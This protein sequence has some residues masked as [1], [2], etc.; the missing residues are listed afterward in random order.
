MSYPLIILG[1]GASYDYSQM[2]ELGE[3]SPLTNDLVSRKHIQQDLLQTYSG[4][5]VIMSTIIQQVTSGVRSFEEALTKLRD[6]SAG[7]LITQSH[8]VGLEFYLQKFFHRIS[9]N[10]DISHNAR[11]MHGINNY[12]SLF[13]KI[14][15]HS[16]GKACLVTFNYDSLLERN[17]PVNNIKR[18]NDYVNGD[19]KI[20][21]LHGSHDWTYIQRKDSFFFG[22]EFQDGY[23]LCCKEPSFLQKIKETNPPI[24]L[25]EIES[26]SE[27]RDFFK[28]PALAIPL[29]GKDK[30]LCPVTHVNSLK[31]ELNCIDRILIIG[32]KA[33]D[34]WLLN[35]LKEHNTC[36]NKKI[37]IVSGSSTG[38]QEVAKVLKSSLGVNPKQVECYEGGFT[39]FMGD[40][41][42]TDFFS[43]DA[44]LNLKKISLQ[45]SQISQ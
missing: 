44:I 18:M 28:F 43:T 19:K 3:L 23:E 45:T 1:A 35:L 2:G 42:C 33:G 40:D 29:S 25:S 12:K 41:L 39:R 7:S 4:V 38:A 21:K 8:F 37:L 15:M 24:I 20:I 17:L 14:D 30:F 31:E 13:N 6:S 26:H 22:R 11:L 10:D 16:A 36:K 27:S 5:G 34:P 32:W 9:T